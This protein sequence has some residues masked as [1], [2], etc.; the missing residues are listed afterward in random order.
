[1]HSDLSALFY[2][3]MRQ[4]VNQVHAIVSRPL[5]LGMYA[6]A[7]LYFVSLGVLRV[8]VG[9]RPAV[10]H[11]AEPYASAVFFASLALLAFT[12][13][14]AASGHV[15]TFSSPADARFIIGSRISERVALTWLQLRRH[16]SR[17]VRVGLFVLFYFIFFGG[18]IRFLGVGLSALF[19]TV[20]AGSLAIPSLA[21]AQRTRAPVRPIIAWCIVLASATCLLLLA[22]R[23]SSLASPAADAIEHL[24]AGAVTN[25][26]LAGNEGALAVLALVAIVA[27]IASLF[28]GRD[29]Y[30]ELYAASQRVALSG[31][32]ARRGMMFARE[33][34][35]EARSVPGAE[36]L[37]LPAGSTA[38]IFWKE[39]LG[40]ARSTG[41]QRTFWICLAIAGVAGVVLAE[42]AAQQHHR[43]EL[44]AFA[45]AA[46]AIANVFILFMAFST[47]IALRDD[48]A[49]P[50]WWMGRDP[51]WL[52]LVAWVAGAS[53]RLVA[54][55]A[56]GLAA[57]AIVARW[58]GLA[59][60]GIPIA[61]ALVVY[62]R[63]I[64]L[65]LYA[66]FPSALDQRG[67]LGMVRAFLCY[68]L[69]A[70]VIAAVAV[71]GLIL[72]SGSAAFTVGIA[73][74]LLLAYL[75]LLFAAWRIEGSGA[76]FAR[77][78]TLAG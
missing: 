26:L 35:Y 77:A 33:Q 36:R 30:P 23:V 20:I 70:P 12:T 56:V 67:P 75:L 42:V 1:M 48:L 68:L 52:R 10:A 74:T 64:G 24:R 46:F 37:L 34:R 14:V 9:H 62:V 25:A 5:R 29:L 17:L 31:I 49:K 7:V 51:L 58:A 19:G 18:Q 76:A 22:S 78:E 4:L 15:G 53:W 3:E 60:A 55:A 69:A 63:S 50:L 39:Y 2:L 21:L 73:S 13:Y 41:A 45:S 59:Y 28:S 57:A 40:F 47:G 54:Y 72:R 65:A 32:R 8:A 43:M 71:T 6:L 38:T 66:L 11:L 16:A 27:S 61:I 44:A